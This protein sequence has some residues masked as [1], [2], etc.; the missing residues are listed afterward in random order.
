MEMTRMVLV[1]AMVMTVVWYSKHV[2]DVYPTVDHCCLIH[3][4]DLL[5]LYPERGLPT[6]TYCSLCDIAKWRNRRI[7]NLKLIQ[8]SKPHF[9][10]QPLTQLWKCLYPTRL[11]QS[12]V[13]VLWQHWKSLRM[14]ELSKTLYVT[15][16]R[17][18]L[19]QLRPHLNEWR[20]RWNHW[21]TIRH[22]SNVDKK[23]TETENKLPPFIQVRA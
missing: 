9:A 19:N 21:N 8:M 7:L 6:I 14:S 18:H 3:W 16:I 15:H 2:A 20:K 4:S 12:T 17:D 11:D 1:T 23:R 5:D 22:T 10:Y 13:V